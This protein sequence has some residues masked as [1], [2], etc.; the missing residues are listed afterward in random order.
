MPHTK[1]IAWPGSRCQGFDAKD[2]LAIFLPG[3]L[4][5]LTPRLTPSPWPGFRLPGE[6]LSRIAKRLR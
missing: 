4:V 6:S 3:E 1:S 2:N 5:E